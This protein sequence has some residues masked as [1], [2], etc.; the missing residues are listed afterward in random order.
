MKLF[1]CYMLGLMTALTRYNINSPCYLAPVATAACTDMSSTEGPFYSKPPNA[2][3]LIF[4][5]EAIDWRFYSANFF[6]NDIVW[7]VI[8]YVH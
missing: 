5:N 6:V 3:I 1:A 8:T 7:L 4:W 2:D